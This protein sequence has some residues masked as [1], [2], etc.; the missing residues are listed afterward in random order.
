MGQAAEG[1]AVAVESSVGGVLKARN[2]RGAWLSLSFLAR[3]ELS[4]GRLSRL[5]SRDAWPWLPSARGEDG[6]GG[7][8]GRHHHR[9]G[10]QR[11]EGLEVGFGQWEVHPHRGAELFKRLLEALHRRRTTSVTLR[12]RCGRV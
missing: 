8:G 9:Q 4:R 1:G 2:G 10:W 5:F 11:H 7:P 6:G 12:T 3:A